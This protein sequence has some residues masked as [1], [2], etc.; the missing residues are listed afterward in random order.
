VTDPATLAS[1]VDRMLV[2]YFERLRERLGP[3]GAILDV[4]THIGQNDPDGFTQTPS[5]LI[6]QLEA[7][8]ARG[9]TFPMHEPDGYEAANDFAIAAAEASNGRLSAFCRVDPLSATTDPVTEAERCL[10]AGAVGIKLHPRAEGFTLSEPSV[11]RLFGLAAERRV[12]ILVHAGRGI[13]ALG[14]DSVRLTDAYPDARLI[15]AHGGISDLAWLQALVEPGS[16]LFFDTAWWNPADLLALFAYVPSSQILWASDSPYGPPLTAFVWHL[17]CA[18]QAGLGTEAIRSLAG[19]QAARILAGE[20]IE[21]FERAPGEAKPLEPMLERVFTHLV[22]AFGASSTGGDPAE[23]IDLARLSCAVPD[24]HPEAPLLHELE[25]L[26][27]DAIAA[28]LPLDPETEAGFG[29]LERTLVSLLCLART[30]A[31]GPAGD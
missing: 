11:E 15:L 18:L 21:L 19:G 8:G 13:P 31:A 7:I 10:E 20:E 16:N 4:H 24:D 3:D 28:Y 12:P 5:E 23:R 17:R 14:R 26:I 30:P 29:D 27:G 6:A 25:R 1:P 2:P 9:V 22:S